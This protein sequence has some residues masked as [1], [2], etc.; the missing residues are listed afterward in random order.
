MKEMEGERGERNEGASEPRVKG[1]KFGKND[2]VSFKPVDFLSN[3][4]SRKPAGS[5]VIFQFLEKRF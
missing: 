1:S 5:T 2:A 4:I 3:S